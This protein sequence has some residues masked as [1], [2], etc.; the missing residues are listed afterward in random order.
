MSAFVKFLTANIWLLV[1]AVICVDLLYSSPVLAQTGG[2]IFKK[3]AD[4][5]A[6]KVMPKKFG[7]MISAFAGVFALLAS[8]TGSYK[9]G[10]ALLFVSIGAFIFKDIAAIL[11]PSTFTGC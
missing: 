5:L 6:C 2:E 3:S 10:W 8:V 7:V 4:G 1:F 11:Y 9:A